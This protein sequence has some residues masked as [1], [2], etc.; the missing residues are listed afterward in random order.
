[1]AI[2]E[3]REAARMKQETLAKLVGVKPPSVS[4]WENGKSMPT[5]EN[6]LKLADIF[7]VTTDEVLGRS[8]PGA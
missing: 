1:M 5:V 7:G 8:R 2:R 3:L 4:A 6:V